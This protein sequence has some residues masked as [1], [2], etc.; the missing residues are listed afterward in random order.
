MLFLKEKGM[1]TPMP[2][3]EGAYE[4]LAKDLKL[5]KTKGEFHRVQSQALIG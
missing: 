3:P 5:A 2:L 4:N 1:R